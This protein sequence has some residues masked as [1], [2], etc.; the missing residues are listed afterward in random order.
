MKRTV[1]AAGLLALL[2]PTF[3]FAQAHRAGSGVQMKP[4]AAR[5]AADADK[6]VVWINSANK[7]LMYWN[8][9]NN[10][11]ISAAVGGGAYSTIMDEGSSLTSRSAVN[12]IGSNITCVDNA[13]SSRTDCTVSGGGGG[14]GSGL[15]PAYSAGTTS[16]DN[17]IPLTSTLGPVDIRDNATPLGTN[18]LVVQNSGAT[19]PFFEVDDTWAY[20]QG[21]RI[22][23]TMQDAYD[24][25]TSAKTIT[26]ARPSTAQ[27]VIA[28]LTT[29]TNRAN[30]TLDYTG[31]A[32]EGTADTTNSPALAWTTNTATGNTWAAQLVGTGTLTGDLVFSSRNGVVEST[33][34]TDN[35]TFYSAGGV[36]IT[37]GK[38]G[39][40]VSHL[41]T[42]PPVNGDTFSLI[43]TAQTFSAVKTFSAAPVFGAGATASGSSAFN[44][45]G[46]TGSMSMPTG[47]S[48]FGGSSNTF[49]AAP[50][51]LSFDGT[52]GAACSASTGGIRYNNT[53]HTLQFCANAGSWTDFGS[54]GGGG[55][56][57][58][59][60]AA[61]Q[62]AY[63]SGANTIQGSS[64]LTYNGSALALAPSA[65]SSGAVS[66]WK[67]T[68]AANT[69]QTA[70]TEVNGVLYDLSATRTWATGA[71]ATQREFYVKA[72][73]Y[74][75][76]G[77]STITTAATFAINN[78]PTAGTNATITNP[79][80]LNVEAGVTHLAG[81]T[82]IGT[83][84]KPSYSLVI[85]PD[86]GA[87]LTNS[88]L[89][90][91]KGGGTSV[92]AYIGA[93]TSHGIEFGWNASSSLTYVNAPTSV[94][95]AFMQGGTARLQ[96]DS[97]GNVDPGADA[98]NQLGLI[99][100]RWKGLFNSANLSCGFNTQAG[101]TYTAVATD[102]W[103]SLT[104][105]A[106][107]TVTMP[108]AN[109]VPAGAMVHLLDGA[110]NASTQNISAARAGT[111]TINGGTT[112]V[113]VVTSNNAHS[114]CVSDGSS[115][116][117]CG[118]NN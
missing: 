5:P 48:T 50:I 35:V 7:H 62:V 82:S 26:I 16:A 6:G 103:V 80:A 23:S 21:Q 22:A 73:A 86:M 77:A 92:S 38:I 81:A 106:A 90:V 118:I 1:F 107:K 46:S 27:P 30:G 97:N 28:K 72:P 71:I 10:F 25:S 44:L 99:N 64:T 63:G 33:A 2:W 79:I 95:M 58:G 116:W 42:I 32:L 84:L 40:D 108:A 36:G 117:V 66:T 68:A 91:S 11:D 76:A 112:N 3:A 78:S 12:F 111:D 37:N 110:A 105:A 41:N 113:A 75:F 39:T 60:I 43:G 65:V 94:S 96:L 104:N 13:G 54:G 93:D 31:L 51:T 61:N 74:A 53:S 29:G 14:G 88:S 100:F 49:S 59:S 114:T 57:G 55:T 9:L 8:L 56:I 47:A 24:N 34:L 115:K 15:G 87:G 18:L 102:C 109:A 4:Q 19:V 98:T 85:G 67:V 83:A 52:G 20:V 70:S 101:T 17:V 89:T 69:G 45:S